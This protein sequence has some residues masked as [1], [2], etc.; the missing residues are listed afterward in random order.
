MEELIKL[1]YTSYYGK[2]IL[3]FFIIGVLFSCG[4]FSSIIGSFLIWLDKR[5]K[6]LRGDLD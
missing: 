3:V 2:T 4:C 5:I 1:L 6:F